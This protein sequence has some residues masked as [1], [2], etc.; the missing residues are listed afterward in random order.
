MCE[1]LHLFLTK[2]KYLASTPIH[3]Q[4]SDPWEIERCVFKLEVSY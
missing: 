4:Y 2:M 3:K 1:Q